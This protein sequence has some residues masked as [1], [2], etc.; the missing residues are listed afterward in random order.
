MSIM[1]RLSIMMAIHGFLIP[2]LFRHQPL[3]G[4]RTISVTTSSRTNQFNQV[5]SSEPTLSKNALAKQNQCCKSELAYYDAGMSFVNYDRLVT[6]DGHT[7]LLYVSHG[8]QPPL[9]AGWW[10]QIAAAQPKSPSLTATGTYTFTKP[11]SI[12]AQPS[13]KVAQS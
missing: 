1:T 12:K 6:A 5:P 3:C 8:G 2:Q 4:Y 9:H 10:W 11:S 7:W 13:V